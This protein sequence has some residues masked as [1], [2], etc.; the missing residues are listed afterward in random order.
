MC[1][2]NRVENQRIETN[3]T[4]YSLFVVQ[5]GIET[6]S[7]GCVNKVQYS[8]FIAFHASREL[9]SIY[10]SV[11]I[12]QK[13]A[14]ASPFCRRILIYFVNFKT[15]KCIPSFIELISHFA[16]K[17]PTQVPSIIYISH[18]GIHHVILVLHGSHQNG[19]NMI[20]AK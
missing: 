16:V 10:T 3:A 18:G 7:P 4:C 5:N 2:Q 19:L 6:N 20:R 12:S 14:Q 15:K 13:H 8:S 11:A 1:A 9:I 17:K